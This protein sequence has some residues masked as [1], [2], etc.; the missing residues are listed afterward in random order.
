MLR[1]CGPRGA[2]AAR[3]RRGFWTDIVVGPYQA[4]GTKC[5][6]PNKHAEGLFEIMNKGTGTE[7]HRHNAV[8]VA[9]YNIISFL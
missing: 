8:H 5:H 2:S 4:L 3:L 7:Q 9:V 6:C 1:P